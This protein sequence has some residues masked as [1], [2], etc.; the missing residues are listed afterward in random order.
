MIKNLEPPL[1]IPGDTIAIAATARKINKTE[2]EFAISFLEKNGFKIKVDHEVFHEYHQFAGTDTQRANHMQNLITNIR[3]TPIS[4]ARRG[5]RTSGLRARR[6]ASRCTGP[7]G[8]V[9]TRRPSA[10]SGAGSPAKKLPR[11]CRRCRSPDA[12][13]TRRGQPARTPSRPSSDAAA[14]RTSTRSAASCGP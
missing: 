4:T 11:R 8:S 7:I 9:R 13:R 6:P 10:S 5:S 14:T 3:L 1:L 12:S 2:I